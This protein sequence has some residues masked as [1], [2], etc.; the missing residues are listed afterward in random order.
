MVEVDEG[1]GEG[2]GVEI[3]AASQHVAEG[4][5]SVGV[6]VGRKRASI[7]MSKRRKKA[8]KLRPRAYPC[9]F[10][11]E[12]LGEGVIAP[13]FLDKEGGSESSK[14]TGK[15]KKKLGWQVQMFGPQGTDYKRQCKI[16]TD[17]ISWKGSTTTPD[18][19]HFDS[20]HTAHMHV[21]Y[22]R[23]HTPHVQLPGETFPRG[24]YV[25]VPDGYVE[26]WSHAKSWSNVPQN[27]GK[28]GRG[29]QRSGGIERF[30]T[31]KLSQAQLR[32]AI[33]KLVVT[34]DLPFR[35]VESEAELEAS[36]REHRPNLRD[37][38]IDLIVD[39]RLLRMVRERA[40]EQAP[41]SGQQ[42]GTGEGGAWH[43][44]PTA[45]GV[46]GGA[47]A[48][49]I[50][51]GMIGASYG[52]LK[53][54]VEHISVMPLLEGRHDLT[55]WV[56]AIRPQ[57][58]ARTIQA[59]LLTIGQEV[60]MA[61]F[62][63]HVLK[64]LPSEYGFLRRKLDISSPDMTVERVCSEVLMEEQTL[65][66]EQ[67][68]K[69]ITTDASA[70]SGA[71]NTIVALTGVNGKEGKGGKEQT[72]KKKD[73]KRE[74]KRAPF[75]GRRYNC[76]E[77]GHMAAKCHNKK[78]DATPTA[79]ANIAE[80]DGKGVALTVACSAAKL[81]AYDKD[82]WFLDSGCS[83]HMTGRKE[84]FTVI[85]DPSATKSVKGF[86]GSMQEVAGVDK[87]AN[88]Q[89]EEGVTRIIA[90]GGQVAATARYCHHLLCLDLKPWPASNGTMAAT[91]CNGT[92]AAAACNGSTA[93][94]KCNGM[95][96]AIAEVASSN[97]RMKAGA[98]SLK[99]YAVGTK[100]TPD[101]W[102]A[103]LGHIHFDAVKRT[104][105]SSG[106]FGMDLEKGV[107]SVQG[108]EQPLDR[109]VGPMGSKAPSAPP[110]LDP[111]SVADSAPMGP[112][113]GHLEDGGAHSST[114]RP[115]SRPNK[116][117]PPVRFQ[118]SAMSAQDADYE[119]NPYDMAY[120][121]EDDCD[122]D[123]DDE[124][125]YLDK[126]EEE[127]G[128]WGGVILDLAAALTGPE[129]KECGI[130]HLVLL[131]T[132]CANKKFIPSRWTVSRDTVVF[133]EA[134]L[135][136][137]VAE[138]M[139]KEGGLGC[140]V[141]FTID[142]WTAPNGKAWLVFREM[143][144]RHTGDDMA[145]VV[146]E[147][148]VQWGLQRRCLGLTTDNA[149]SNIAAFRRLSE[150]RGGLGF[151]NSRMHFRCLAHVINLAVQAALA[152]ATIRRLLKILRAMATW[153]GLTPQCSAAFLG[154][155]RTFNMQAN[156][157]KKALKLV[158]DN[159]TRWGSTYDMVDRT[160]AL[161][162]PIMMYFASTQGLSKDDKKKVA[163]MRRTDADWER[164]QAVKTFVSPFAK[165]SKAAEGA[166]YPTVS[167]VVP[168]YNGLIDAIEARL[169]KG[170]SAM[171]EPMVV[172]ALRHLKKYAYI[173]SNE[174]WICTFLN[175]SMKAAWFDDAHWEKM[176]PDT[177]RRERPRPSSREVITL[178][179]ERV[180]EYQARATELAPR[181]TTLAIVREEDE[182]EEG[183][184]EDAQ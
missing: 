80:G 106:M 1:V 168:Y 125:E 92:V 11:R 48:P 76:N 24:G 132:N 144:G 54:G 60:H 178:V 87:G 103:R 152:V 169:A 33:A 34:C 171:L 39:G 16:C 82:L 164:L 27:K 145:H 10:T 21:W 8:P 141:S 58:Q 65:S 74:K 36:V 64:G 111:L 66:I 97:P 174:Y 29:E 163:K 167:M 84:W 115:S 78:K 83:Q 25:G 52:Q 118:P 102:H 175:P 86:D 98:A 94:V 63:A 40:A 150:E 46:G 155:Q 124:V 43:E 108:G 72:D 89:T 42:G 165:V 184:D 138:L 105:T 93:A 95:A 114:P 159:P 172:A 126:N 14:G 85:R 90:S 35:V 161:Q 32:Q 57:L 179:R 4:G 71:V 130:L 183:D 153:I 88:L 123:S 50:D 133:A 151:F 62:A 31:T 104:A 44:A 53:F 17:R 127:E 170:P 70:F 143:L 55:A 45:M 99:V 41:A 22:H 136:S 156:S 20:Y 5:G 166:A 3:E 113:D 30:M 49:N 122:T 135:Q 154:F 67:S 109:S 177:P 110:P 158:Q 77:E 173:T 117:V 81:L 56:S 137:A 119:E 147:T 47:V 180:V 116:G 75:K 96:K 181:P 120:L 7:G 121:A 101:L 142:M 26:D 112:E 182:G 23:Y 157:N 15:G 18:E 140:K 176:H 148:V 79:A 160:C 134:A 69:Q 91:A 2:G 38:E 13:K 12:P 68:Y 139:A 61:T 131:N 19:R 59:E 37:E 162:N 149:S 28:A 51:A 9:T 73:G 129:G 100:A 146:E 107:P 6:K 128:A